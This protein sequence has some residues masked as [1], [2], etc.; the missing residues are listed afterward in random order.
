MQCK[1]LLP[2]AWWKGLRKLKNVI[3]DLPYSIYI[4]GFKGN[5]SPY[6]TCITIGHSEEYI[7]NA[8]WHSLGIIHVIS[9]SERIFVIKDLSKPWCDMFAILNVS[10]LTKPQQS[11]VLSNFINHPVFYH[12]FHSH[13]NTKHR[14]LC[15]TLVKYV[16]SISI[17]TSLR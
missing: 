13:T 6:F 2:F 4:Y 16:R 12:G 17:F 10:I 5:I 3:H 11:I 9:I 1:Y 8:Q 15:H 14:T 7:G